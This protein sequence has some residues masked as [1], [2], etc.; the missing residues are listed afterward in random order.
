MFFLVLFIVLL[1]AW[2]SG[3]A[4]FHIAGATLHLILV[5]AFVSLVV[6]LVRGA[7]RPHTA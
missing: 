5:L 7:T 6:H 1:L 2:I 4:L 3:W